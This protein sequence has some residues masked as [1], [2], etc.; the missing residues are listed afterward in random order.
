MLEGDPWQISDAVSL[1]SSLFSSLLPSEPQLSWALGTNS[2]I[3]FTHGDFYAL[4]AFSLSALQLRHFLQE[5]IWENHR[6]HLMYFPFLRGYCP[7][8]PDIQCHGNYSFIYFIHLFSCFLRKVNLVPVTLVRCKNPLT[9]CKPPKAGVSFTC[10][11]FHLCT[12]TM[13]ND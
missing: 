13:H 9:I 6:A 2:F 4:P 3:F 12:K 8:F 1:C 11:S 10:F 7:F 5:V